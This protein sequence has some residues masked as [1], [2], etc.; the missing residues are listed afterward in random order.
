MEKG[1]QMRWN[2]KKIY[3]WAKAGGVKPFNPER[4]NP[5]SIDLCVGEYYRFP[6]QAGW[7]KMLPIPT[8]GV[9]F[10]VSDFLL[11]HTWEY[12]KIPTYDVGDLCLK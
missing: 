3:D 2:D 4:I 10:H 6:T 11:L 12:I 9:L 1:K 5:A 7:S 8:D